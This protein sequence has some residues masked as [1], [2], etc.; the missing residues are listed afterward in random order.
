MVIK[1]WRARRRPKYRN[2]VC[3]WNRPIKM[4]PRRLPRTPPAEPAIQT[5]DWRLPEEDGCLCLV[6][7][8]LCLA[9]SATMASFATSAIEA[10]R[11]LRRRYMEIVKIE[12]FDGE[13]AM[14][15]H[16]SACKKAA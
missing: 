12:M 3:G 13:I 2:M 6:E 14:I 11:L 1:N 9:I 4:P 16:D 8:G 5:K 10:P 15:I 7:E